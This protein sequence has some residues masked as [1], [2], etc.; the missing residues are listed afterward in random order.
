M[1]LTL[2]QAA[3]IEQRLASEKKSIPIAYVL[4]VIFGVFSVYRFYFG[5]HGLLFLKVSLC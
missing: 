4:L 5:R 3:I 1:R 2:A